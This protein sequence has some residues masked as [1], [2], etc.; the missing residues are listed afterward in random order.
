MEKP[1]VGSKIRIPG[2]M[3]KVAVCSCLL[4][5]YFTVFA[6]NISVTTDQGMGEDDGRRN[7]TGKIS[8]NGFLVF[9]SHTSSQPLPDSL[10]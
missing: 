1:G 2:Q 9:I 7:D 10:Q 8:N 6:C 5:I 4:S 3:C